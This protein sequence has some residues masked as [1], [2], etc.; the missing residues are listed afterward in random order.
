MSSNVHALEGIR[1]LRRL[2][3]IALAGPMSKLRFGPLF[4]GPATTQSGRV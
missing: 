1:P 3:L 2:R 4:D